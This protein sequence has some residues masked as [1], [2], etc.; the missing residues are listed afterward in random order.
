MKYIKTRS[1]HNELDAVNEELLGGIFKKLFSN[2]KSKIAINISKSIGS[3]GEID[4]LLKSYRLELIKLRDPKIMAIKAIGEMQLAIDN[5]GEGD[6]AELKN[7]VVKY[8]KSEEVIDKQIANAKAKFDTQM[9][10]IIKDEKS[11]YV[12]DYITLK[13]FDMTQEF[14]QTELDMINSGIGLSA[15]QIENSPTLKKMSTELT[16]KAK[17]VGTKKTEIEKTITDKDTNN[18]NAPDSST[19]TEFDVDEAEKNDNYVWNSKFTNGDYAFTAGEALKYWSKGNKKITDAF[20]VDVDDAKLNRD[21]K[22][23]EMLITTTKDDNSKAFPILKGKVVSTEKDGAVK[24]KND[25]TSDANPEE[26]TKENADAGTDTT[27]V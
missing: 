15:E 8:Q 3:V 5:G 20:Y 25:K 19:P 27:T 17:E 9:A 22:D 23:G 2:I 14:L 26:D 4:K 16:N 18:E 11:V 1:H 6:P 10:N 21:L 7:L 12:N 24:A 13:K